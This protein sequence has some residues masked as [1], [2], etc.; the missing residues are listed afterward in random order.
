MLSGLAIGLSVTN[1]FDSDPP[2]VNNA[3]GWDPGQASAL[4]RLVAFTL[5]KKF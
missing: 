1:L 3:G 5:T 4:G 2:F